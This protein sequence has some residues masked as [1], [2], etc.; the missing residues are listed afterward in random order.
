MEGA[1]DNSIFQKV[2]MIDHKVGPENRAHAFA[3]L[4]SI[5]IHLN[6]AIMDCVLI[7]KGHVAVSLPVCSNFPRERNFHHLRHHRQFSLS[8]P[9]VPFVLLQHCI[10]AVSFGINTW[11]GALYGALFGAFTEHCLEHII[12]GTLSSFS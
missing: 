10:A 2:A 9:P 7:H 1:G 5:R 11:I 6:V 12:T 3:Y 8:L 4:L